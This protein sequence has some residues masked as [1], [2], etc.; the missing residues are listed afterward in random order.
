MI[1]INMSYSQRL[2]YNKYMYRIRMILEKG[3]HLLRRDYE[4]DNEE[5]LLQTVEERKDFA[6]QTFNTGNN[7][8]KWNFDI[9]DLSKDQI[10]KLTKLY[11]YRENFDSTGKLRVEVPCIDFYTNNI[12][13]FKIAEDLELDPELCISATDEPNVIVVDKLPF[14]SYKFKCLTRYTYVDDHTIS[15]LVEYEN[16][17]EIK[18]PW[19]W[20]TRKFMINRQFSPLP[21]YI[22]AQDEE[23]IT[24][25]TLIAGDVIGTVYSYRLA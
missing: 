16:S 21:N 17:G 4:Y 7:G 15:A 11:H 1:S 22:Y 18:F 3:V 13:Y 5:H 24:W 2:F 23:N 6:R 9:W 8:F 14:E 12:D 25:V 20:T 19:N 10:T